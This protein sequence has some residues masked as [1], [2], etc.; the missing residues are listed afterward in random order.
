MEKVLVCLLGSTRAHQLTFPSFKRQV[1]DELKGDLALALAIDEKYEYTNPFW[2][3]AK[4][5]WT[6][7]LFSDFGE[8]FDLAQHWLCQ[9]RN[10][11]APNWRLMLQINGMWQGLIQSPDPQ[12]GHSSLLFFC[13]WL[14]LQGLK[15]DDV[16]HRYDRFVI[17]RSDFVWLCPHPPLSILDRGAIW[18][19]D[20]EHWG[21][22]NDRHL[23]V[24]RADVVDCLNLIEDILL[25]PS[26]LYR[27]LEYMKGRP[28]WQNNIE[29]FIAH[30]LRRKGLFDKVKTFPYVM[31]L[32][33]QIGDDTRTWTLGDY[34]PAVGHYIKYKDEFRTASAYAT[35]IK[36]RADWENGAWRQFDPALVPLAPRA[37]SMPRRFRYACSRF[38]YACKSG[39]FWYACWYA[40]KSGSEKIVSA[41]RRPERVKRF[42]LFSESV[43]R[44]TYDIVPVFVRQSIAYAYRRGVRPFLPG[45]P[46]RYAGIFI[47]QDRKWGD[48][49]VPITWVPEEVREAVHGD[50]RGYAAALVEGLR[51][52]VRPGDSVV[53]VGAGLG[54]TAVVAAL[55]AGP[56]GT[57]QCFE[58]SREYVTFAQQTATRNKVTNVSVHHAVVAK[59]NADFRGGVANDLGPILSPSQLPPCNVLQMDCEGAEV[60][61]LPGLMIQPRVI[62]VETHGVF[63]APTNLVASLLE[64]RGYVVTDRGLA[65]PRLAELHT[66]CDIRVLLGIVPESK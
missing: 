59:F 34:E 35:I 63:G 11:A 41:L 43:L 60:D 14:L 12:P 7:P 29:Q 33:R 51:E 8:A 15:Q 48:H 44:R 32:A 58:G 37:I 13:R 22:L 57:V 38:W 26:Q 45:Q 56:S 18:F 62:L 17:T 50:Q 25:E 49:L 47:C 21:G 64:K 39:S 20:G 27:E 16:L 3:H 2:L 46:V 9:E 42:L 6:A 28:A 55:R 10:I 36:S 4:Y 66:K 61:I 52:T 65:E 1:L 5:R 54:V 30:H 23:V 40:C 24:S 31:Y 53:I 19:P